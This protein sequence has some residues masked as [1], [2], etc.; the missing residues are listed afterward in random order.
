MIECKKKIQQGKESIQKG[1]IDILGWVFFKYLYFEQV[2]EFFNIAKGIY[3]SAIDNSLDIIDKELKRLEILEKNQEGRLKS[4]EDFLTDLVQQSICHRYS[5]I[6]KERIND[7]LI[8]Y[9]G[10]G[11]ESLN[12]NQMKERGDI[13]LWFKESY[14]D[15]LNFLP[16]CF[17]EYDKKKDEI[18]N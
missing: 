3:L 12:S 11:D 15:I 16:N 4:N 18:R 6:F 7:L 17:D 13:V 14:S 2:E 1:K 5:F 10:P 9:L 8:C